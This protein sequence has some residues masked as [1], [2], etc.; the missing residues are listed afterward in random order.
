MNIHEGTKPDG[1]APSRRVIEKEG[2]VIDRLEDFYD[3]LLLESDS[4]IGP[5]TLKGWLINARRDYDKR[6]ACSVCGSKVRSFMDEENTT[7]EY[8]SGCGSV[9]HVYGCDEDD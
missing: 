1:P 8:C 2:D 4:P 6:P 3:Y 9:Y 5:T 7:T